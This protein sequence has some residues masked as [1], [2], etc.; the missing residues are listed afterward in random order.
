MKVLHNNVLLTEVEVESKTEGGII[1]SQSISTGH[2][3]ARIIAVGDA[4]RD[5]FPEIKA[6]G[7]VYCDWKEAMPV[8][9]E[10][11]KCAVIDVKHI[12]LVIE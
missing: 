6:K 8:E 5:A 7:K 9:I 2:K 3:P 1:L 4:V 12:K 11:L 10:G